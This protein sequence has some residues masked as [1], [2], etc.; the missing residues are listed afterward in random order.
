M[1]MAW[2]NGM[3]DDLNVL[4]PI[5]KAGRIVLPKDIREELAIKPGNV[6]RVGIHGSA[7]TLTL[8]KENTGFVRRGKALVFSTAGD[9]VLTAGMVQN[10]L[11]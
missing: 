4:V 7:V 11:Y 2:S 1:I 6:L 8:S 10:L 9:E 5:D 3:K